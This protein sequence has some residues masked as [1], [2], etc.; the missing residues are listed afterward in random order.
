MDHF[1]RADGF[2]FLIR[3]YG[4]ES[5]GYALVNKKTGQ[6]INLYSIPI[7]S[8]DGKRIVDVSLDLDAG[9]QPNLIR[10]YKLRDKKYAIEWKH[11]YKD[12]KGPANPV[13]LNNSAIVFFEVTFD[14]VPTASNLRKKPFIIELENNKWN[15]PRPVE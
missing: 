5:N 10:I 3:A 2:Y 1:S 14:K 12:L 4:Y 9:Y 11:I 7:F 6:T 13:W 8:P 15:R